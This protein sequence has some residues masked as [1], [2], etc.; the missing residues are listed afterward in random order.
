MPAPPHAHTH[1]HTLFYI[2]KTKMVNKGKKSFRKE[3]IKR[4][5][6]RSKCY[7]FSHFRASRIQQL[8]LSA[9]YSYQQ[10]FSLFDSPSTLKSISSTLLNQLPFTRFPLKEYHQIP[11]SWVYPPSLFCFALKE[12]TLQF[13]YSFWSFWEKCLSPAADPNWKTMIH[14]DRPWL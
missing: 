6:L 5:S 10:Y 14:L 7:C 9:N 2:A 13:Y 8:F 3:A 12:P 4:L 11:E 1:T